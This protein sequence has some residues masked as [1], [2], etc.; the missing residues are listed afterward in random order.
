MILIYRFSETI[1][2]AIGKFL[3]ATSC[4][5]LQQPSLSPA[6]QL[7][8]AAATFSSPL[9]PQSSLSIPSSPSPQQPSLSPAPH[10][11]SSPTPQVPSQE[12]GEA[13]DA[14]VPLVPAGVLHQQPGPHSFILPPTGSTACPLCP[15]G[16]LIDPVAA[17]LLKPI[18]CSSALRR[19]KLICS[20]P[21]ANS[22]V[23]LDSADGVRAHNFWMYYCTVLYYRNIVLP[24]YTRIA[25][26]ARCTAV[27]C[28]TTA[29]K[30]YGRTDGRTVWD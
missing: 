20:S 2:I 4:S 18:G 17:A 1:P 21:G 22:T 11:P 29:T 27:L 3:A 12:A 15:T 28:T 6:P 16:V 10:L 26:C 7:P 30:G 8:Q 24:E 14:V 19:L 25:G 13:G 5:Y 23:D 9:Y